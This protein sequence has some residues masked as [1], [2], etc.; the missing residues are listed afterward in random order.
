MGISE[1]QIVIFLLLAAV[2]AIAVATAKSD[3]RMTRYEYFGVIVAIVIANMVLNAVARASGGMIAGLLG[4]AANLG[5]YFLFTRASVL[6]ARD[7]GI[8]KGYCYLMAFPPTGLL[9]M[10][11]LTCKPSPVR[12]EPAA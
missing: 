5:I 9:L 1:T 8:A 12:A 7:A 10:L 2:A 3:G 11:V 4:I 6:R